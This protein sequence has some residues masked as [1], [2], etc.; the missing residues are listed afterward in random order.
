MERNSVT[1]HIFTDVRLL[2]TFIVVTSCVASAPGQTFSVQPT[3]AVPDNVSR[4]LSLQEAVAFA[5]ENNPELAMLRKQRGIAEAGVVIARTY[6]FNPTWQSRI[7]GVNGPASAGVT[8]HVFVEQTIQI[9]IELRGQGKIR[10]EAA[11]AALSR[12]EWEIA[13]QELDLALRVIRA[14]DTYLYRKAKL[15]LLD[16][17]VV[18]QEK[19]AKTIQLMTDQLKLRAA[20][21]LL[22]QADVVELRAQRGPSRAQMISAWNDLR[23]L[24]AVEKETPEIRGGLSNEVPPLP[25]EDMKGLALQSRPDLHALQMAVHEAEQRRKLEVANRF[26]NPT[27]G[28]SMEYSETNTTFVGVSLAYSL[29]VLNRHRGEILQRQAEKERAIQ[30]QRRLEVQIGL[31]LQ[32]A[33]ARLV[34]AKKSAD[35]FERDVL[36][37]LKSTVKTLNKLFTQG[38]PG[39]DVLRLIETQRRLLRAHDAYLDALWELHQGKADLAQAIGN[40][41]WIM[42]AALANPAEQKTSA[43]PISQPVASEPRPILLPPQPDQP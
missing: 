3:E 10:R 30:D 13:A 15:E 2:L 39:V 14:F 37:T 7:M 23:R 40:I 29:P 4:S 22:A 17:N 24:L 35:Y 1:R 32:S 31:D 19:T 8:N 42:N 26:G 20:D 25:N 36:P 6:P 12:T 9:D 34:E 21:L 38:D 27:I 11:C 28:P 41:A 43:D 16:Q 5:L 33:E 18:L